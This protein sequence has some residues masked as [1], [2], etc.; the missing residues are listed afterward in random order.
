MGTDDWLTGTGTSLTKIKASLPFVVLLTGLKGTHSPCG[1]ELK[2]L[3]QPGSKS[4]LPESLLAVL[5]HKGN[6]HIFLHKN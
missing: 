2:P 1:F 5:Y 3:V 6:T 4:S